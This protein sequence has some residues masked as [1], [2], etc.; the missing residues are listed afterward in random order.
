VIQQLV[1]Q[2][3]RVFG[4]GRRASDPQGPWVTAEVPP[5]LAWENLPVAARRDDG[6]VFKM[7]HVVARR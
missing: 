2:G 6:S 1:A 7:L 4:A 5:T 3:F